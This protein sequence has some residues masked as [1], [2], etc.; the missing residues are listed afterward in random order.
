MLRRLQYLG[1]GQRILIFF[2][3]MIGGLLLIAGITVFL[4]LLSINNAQRV[5]AVGLESGVEVREFASL[6][7]SDAYPAAVA[8]SPDGTVYTGSYATGTIWQIS[9]DGQT[10]QEVPNTRERLGSITGLTAAPDGTLYILDRVNP[11]Y[12]AS[13]GLIWQL[14]PDG[15]LREYAAINDAT[16]F[17]SP[18]DLTLDA[19][20]QL[21]VTD[22][23]RREVWRWS[24]DGQNG[25]L[26][27]S[28]PAEPI[29][30]SPTGL[31]FDPTSNTILITDS[32]SQIIYRV[33]VDNGETTV[34]YQYSDTVN[35]PFFDGITVTPNGQVYVAALDQ[36][37][38]VTFRDGQMVYIAGNFRGSS[39]V[40]IAP[41][42]RLI[43][44]NFDSISLVVPGVSPQLPFALDVIRFGE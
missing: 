28:P 43:V 24:A 11:D 16:G 4:I 26:W 1:T 40:A 3:L 42:G 34:F 6:P 2:L 8:I 23:G 33:G 5:T 41:D 27:W 7:D 25:A 36:N 12:R 38:I 14:S 10:I 31:A 21:Y 9:A 19:A 20:G 15:A 37:G 32:E 17:I 22:R 35:L 29:D 13:G 44:T 18:D 39:D 30:G